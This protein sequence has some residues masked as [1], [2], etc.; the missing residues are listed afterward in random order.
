M[1]FIDSSTYSLGR[2]KKNRC[3]ARELL[4]WRWDVDSERR[5]STEATSFG[6]ILDPVRLCLR[7]LRWH[8]RADDAQEPNI[9]MSARGGLNLNVWTQ[10]GWKDHSFRFNVVYN[11]SLLCSPMGWMEKP[12]LLFNTKG[13]IFRLNFTR[14]STKHFRRFRTKTSKALQDRRRAYGVQGWREGTK[15]L[16]YGP[17]GPVRKEL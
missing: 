9:D 12:H 11:G 6:H 2:K 7:A 1:R 10:V 15:L 5:T 4:N 3:G 16:S 14:V 8:A 17:I 13:M